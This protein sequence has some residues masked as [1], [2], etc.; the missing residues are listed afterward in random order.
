MRR[1]HQNMLKSGNPKQRLNANSIAAILLTCRGCTSLSF[2]P[3][4]PGDLIQSMMLNVIYML[5]ML[6]VPAPN[7]NFP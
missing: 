7:W 6:R 1:R 3:P 5:K 4:D 2:S